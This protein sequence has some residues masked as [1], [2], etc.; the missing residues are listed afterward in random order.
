MKAYILTSNYN[1]ADTCRDPDDIHTEKLGAF[2][3]LELAKATALKYRDEHFFRKDVEFFID[4][5]KLLCLM[6]ICSY[7]TW[8]NIEEIEIQDAPQKS[9]EAVVNSI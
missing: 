8:L 5:R 7:G 1:A 3:S 4:R 9:A 6:D 2:S